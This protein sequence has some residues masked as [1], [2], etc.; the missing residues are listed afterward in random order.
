MNVEQSLEMQ[1]SQPAGDSLRP[2]N[3]VC[4]EGE[5]HEY[6]EVA[7][8]NDMVVRNMVWHHS[9]IKLGIGE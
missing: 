1:V 8:G 9:G 5:G 3:T 4:L 6:Y 2:P 7:S